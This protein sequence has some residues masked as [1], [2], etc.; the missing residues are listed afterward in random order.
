MTHHAVTFR[1][2]LA[3]DANGLR[4][5]ARLGFSDPARP[6]WDRGL[7]TLCH[8]GDRGAARMSAPVTTLASAI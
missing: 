6:A 2:V 8:V 7:V 4:V 1:A 3:L 5:L